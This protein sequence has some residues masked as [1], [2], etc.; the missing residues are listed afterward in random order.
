MRGLGG[1]SAVGLFT[2]NPGG[3]GG[4]EEPGRVY[5]ERGEAGRGRP[6]CREKKQENALQFNSIEVSETGSA[7]K[8]GPQS[9]S[10]SMVRGRY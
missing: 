8:R 10:V 4:R 7:K 2:E 5:G 1:G 6:L 3:G 9:M